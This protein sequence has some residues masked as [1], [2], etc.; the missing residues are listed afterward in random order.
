M[1]TGQKKAAVLLEEKNVPDGRA[2]VDQYC[3]ASPPVLVAGPGPQACRQV[4]ARA[5]DLSPVVRNIE[6]ADVMCMSE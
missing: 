5:R 1:R 4:P 6:S 3:R 2:V